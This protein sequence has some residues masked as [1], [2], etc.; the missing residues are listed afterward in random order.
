MI[1]KQRTLWIGLI[2]L[3]GC[4]GKV[5]GDSLVIELN[6]SNFNTIV[7]GSKNV[8]VEFFAPCT[9]SISI[10]FFYFFFLFLFFV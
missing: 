2:V 1:L 3:F 5:R 7:D 4:F 9:F 6:P 10:S 8:L